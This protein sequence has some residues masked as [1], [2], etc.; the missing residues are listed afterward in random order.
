MW[1]PI[2]REYCCKANQENATA[3]LFSCAKGP[4]SGMLALGSLSPCKTSLNV[5]RN[6]NIHTSHHLVSVKAAPKSYKCNSSPLPTN[7]R[8]TRNASAEPHS[9]SCMRYFGVLTLNPRES[10]EGPGEMQWNKSENLRR[11][12]LEID[13]MDIRWCGWI[14]AVVSEMSEIC[15]VLWWE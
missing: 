6:H 13:W 12:N 9:D 2:D 11:W 8:G 15:G 14:T 5:K 1:S 10:L 7:Q 3:K 4:S